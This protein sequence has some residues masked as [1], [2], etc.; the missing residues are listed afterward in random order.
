VPVV[1]TLHLL[2]IAAGLGIGVWGLLALRRSLPRGRFAVFGL[3]S[4]GALFGCAALG[5][6]IGFLSPEAWF[7]VVAAAMLGVA[8]GAQRFARTRLPST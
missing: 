3:A 8:I 1:D 6:E 2:V 7:A 4:V 5:G